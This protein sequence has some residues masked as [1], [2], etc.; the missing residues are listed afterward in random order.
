MRATSRSVSTHSATVPMLSSSS[1][2]S[3]LSAPASGSTIG[4]AASKPR[5]YRFIRYAFSSHPTE[6]VKS[7]RAVT[8][9][10]Q[11]EGISGLQGPIMS[12]TDGGD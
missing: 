2:S 1:S 5:S 12:A 8:C 9:T 10:G 3:P 6:I 4:D 7:C 11:S